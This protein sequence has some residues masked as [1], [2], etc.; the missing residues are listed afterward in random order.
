MSAPSLLGGKQVIQLSGA[1]Q[2][3]QQAASELMEDG[4]PVTITTMDVPQRSRALSTM[5]PE[6]FMML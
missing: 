1:M 3:D 2:E 4:P 6:D 5:H